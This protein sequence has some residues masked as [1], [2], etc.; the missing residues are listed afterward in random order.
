MLQEETSVST[1]DDEALD[2]HSIPGW[3][4]VDALAQALLALEGLCVTN[5]QAREIKCLYDALSPHDKRPLLFKPRPRRPSTGSFARSKQ[6]SLHKSGH[7]GVDA[8]KRLDSQTVLD[9][10]G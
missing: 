3:T 5:A 9:I 6:G 8:M 2:A 10:C 4:H 1:E 7:V